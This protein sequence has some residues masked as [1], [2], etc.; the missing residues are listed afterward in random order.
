MQVALVTVGDEVLAGDVVN[1]N[2]AWL[3]RQLTARGATVAR[4]IT[5][6]DDVDVVVEAVREYSGAFDA[7][8]TTGGLGGTLDDVTVEAVAAAFDRPLV[9]DE[10][11]REDV[12]ETIARFR[13][14]NPE[15]VERYPDIEIDFDAQASLPEGARPLVNPSGLSPGCVLENVYVLPG[16]PEEMQAMFELVADEFGGDGVAETLYT[17]APEAAT[18]GTLEAARDRFGVAVG[19]YPARDPGGTNRVK[20]VADDPEALTAAVDWLRERIDTVPAPEGDGHEDRGN[21][22]GDGVD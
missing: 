7:V 12:V 11:A 21:E 14:A 13:D 16:I 15:L 10:T 2:A 6:P 3:G 5:V 19:S 22:D 1:T 20:V 8:I 18:T 9:V 4:A 17:P